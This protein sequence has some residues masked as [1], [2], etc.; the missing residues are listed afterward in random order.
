M[1]CI[2]LL[3][4]IALFQA[5]PPVPGKAANQSRQVGK[6]GQEKTAK[7]Q[8]RTNE[9]KPVANL[10]NSP[11]NEQNTPTQTTS[12]EHK[13]EA[14]RVAPIDIHK[15]WTDYLYIL[16]NLLLTLITLGIA[17]FAAIQARAAKRSA[18]NDERS[19][20]LTERADVLLEAVGLTY[21]PSGQLDGR[22]AVKLRFKNFGRTR[23][24]NVQLSADLII[25]GIPDSATLPKMPKIV[26]GAGDDQTATFGN[27]GNY[28]TTETAQGIFKG[29]VKMEFVA[30]ATYDDVFGKSHICECAGYFEHRAKAF[31]CTRTEVKEQK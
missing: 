31:V 17:I 19:V 21:G 10:A 5:L 13:T 22:A 14:V 27:F 4:L 28:L 18:D 15:D 3:C 23:A 6:N 12:D 11:P 9:A 24:T 30:K 25:P 8:A 2:A 16:A 7:D 20:R 1:K 26:M 29:T